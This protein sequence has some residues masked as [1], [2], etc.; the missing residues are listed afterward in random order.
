MND[1][2]GLD[3]IN[4]VLFEVQLLFKEIFA[5]LAQPYQFY[6]FIFKIDILVL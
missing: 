4:L 2:F 1:I 3:V 6:M 5:H